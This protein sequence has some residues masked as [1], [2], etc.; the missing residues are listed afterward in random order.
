MANQT[1]ATGR[2][3]QAQLDTTGIRNY[4]CR[5]QTL[6]FMNIDE[7]G[8]AA[9]P[10]SPHFSKMPAMK[11]SPAASH[12]RPACCPQTLGKTGAV[13]TVLVAGIDLPAH[14]AL[15][16]L[17]AAAATATASQLL[18]R[19]R[20]DPSTTANNILGDDQRARPAAPASTAGTAAALAAGIFR[21]T[22]ARQLCARPH[23]ALA[24]TR[25]PL[26]AVRR[27]QRQQFGCRRQWQLSA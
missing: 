4:S 5:G 9:M 23:Q 16:L 22:L 20:Q 19:L 3:P 21:W 24:A 1:W 12:P 10:T 17:P 6:C 11:C 7:P 14:A 27:F 8:G 15:D 26:R 13:S 2:G 25:Q 18:H